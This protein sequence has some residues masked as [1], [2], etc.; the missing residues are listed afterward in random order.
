MASLSVDGAA[1]P[2]RAAAISARPD[3]E[4]IIVGAGFAGIGAAIR[5]AQ[6]GIDS[7]AVLEQADDLG[8][9]WRDNHYPGC[10]VDIVSPVYS[11][12]FEPRPSWSRLYAP[13]QEM[14][15]YADHC[16]DKY[17]VRQAIRFGQK[18][19]RAHFDEARNRWQVE[20]EGGSTL[21]AR[22]LVMATG[23]LSQ[24]KYPSIE[25]LADFGGKAM[26][27]ARWDHQYDL[28]G[29]RVGLI[30][31]GATSVQLV[32]A[33]A[34]QVEQLHVFQ[35][36]PIWLL[37][38]PDVAF[39]P[40]MQR[41]FALVPMVQ[42]AL[43]WGLFGLTEAL[44]VSLSVHN[45]RFSG[46]GRAMQRK[47]LE[48]LEEQIPDDPELRRRL[49]PGYDFGCKRPSFSNEYWK[50]FTRDDVELVTDPIA[51]VTPAG[52]ETA[53]GQLRELDA[54]VLA[55][56]FKIL[57]RGNLPPFPITGRDDVD[58]EQFWL[59]NRFQAYEGITVPRFPNMFLM[60]GPYSLIA[61]SWFATIEGHATHLLRC[62]EHARKR[63]TTRIEISQRAHDAYFAGIKRRQKGTVYFNAD[64]AGSNSYYFDGRGDAPL[65]RPSTVIEHFL[66][67]RYFPLRHY[68]FT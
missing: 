29:K 21:T 59:D 11:Y 4:V 7:Y 31:T 8:G 13:S 57:E 53:D 38:K 41:L 27:S 1:S 26:H 50:T 30:G 67:H 22:F 32:P 3:F 28:R 25:G 12:S 10:A 62:I 56:G 51:R 23:A 44:M 35:R 65:Q 64:C 49:T 17:G 5:L 54:L 43:R 45:R 68:Q 60:V 24:P 46:L 15:D 58:L 14:K 63:G 34:D 39:P 42:R 9:T 16:A 2:G 66:H 36:T 19:A 48:H 6:A 52:I 20:V 47:C 18:V 40:W 55:T 33:I 61:T 37:P